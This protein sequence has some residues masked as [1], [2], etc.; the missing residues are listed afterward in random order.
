MKIGVIS[1]LPHPTFDEGFYPNLPFGKGT[2]RGVSDDDSNDALPLSNMD[3]SLFL[4]R[5]LEKDSYTSCNS[6]YGSLG[7]GISLIA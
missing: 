3:L 6:F 4:S 1:F 7:L 5:F 2:K